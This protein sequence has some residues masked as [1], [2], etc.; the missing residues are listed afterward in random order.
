MAIANDCI[1]CPEPQN[2][3][4]DI[5]SQSSLVSTSCLPLNPGD[6]RIV[7]SWTEP[8]SEN[9]MTT[10]AFPYEYPT[11]NDSRYR[12]T[13]NSEKSYTMNFSV[14]FNPR[15]GG[16]VTPEQM[17]SRVKKCFEQVSPLLKGPDGQSLELTINE[18]PDSVLE[19]S[20]AISIN[21]IQPGSRGNA[22]NFAEDFEC[23]TIVHEMLHH[24]GLC[25]EYL[26]T[27]RHMEPS[28]GECRFA[29]H[30]R[31]L[32]AVG[33]SDS[34]MNFHEVAYR[35]YVGEQKFCR[36]DENGNGEQT[37]RLTNLNPKYIEIASTRNIRKN[38]L[39]MASFGYP[40]GHTNASKSGFELFCETGITQSAETNNSEVSKPFLRISEVTDN[41]ISFTETKA[42]NALSPTKLMLATVPMTCDCSNQSGLN[43]TVCQKF[44]SRLKVEATAMSHSDSH[45]MACPRG[46][47]EEPLTNESLEPGRISVRSNGIALRSKPV[48]PSGESI[49]YPAQ[50]YR[51]INGECETNTGLE[52]SQ[53]TLLQNYNACARF[54]R[55]FSRG[56]HP[57]TENQPIL[58]CSDRPSFC[59]DTS[60][61]L[62]EK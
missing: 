59:Y 44:L 35:F 2:R 45:I 27:K 34:I 62:G 10:A 61:W 57:V 16:S 17:E 39:T 48:I 15:V 13:R 28:E 46:T 23:G 36:F 51:L 20:S 24:A 38:E 9:R 7:D 6:S 54:T 3:S 37:K 42:W 43:L 55:R 33:A 58:S 60:K 30:P 14:K 32:D 53:L 56:R 18:G 49:L 41:K 31:N 21:I 25:D 22:G 52:R 19:N 26:E 50:F 47:T 8:G 29:D 40:I 11:P 1:N 4:N 12:L 5:I